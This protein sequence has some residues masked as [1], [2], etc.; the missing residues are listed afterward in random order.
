M[1][2]TDN[3]A[4]ITH[5]VVHIGV[6]GHPR[7]HA[8]PRR[9]LYSTQYNAAHGIISISLHGSH[10]I[11]DNAPRLL[12]AALYASCPGGGGGSDA[13]EPRDDCEPARLAFTEEMAA[14]AWLP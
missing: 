7:G 2:F 5:R 1:D 6:C 13:F 4:A 9:L 11:T 14:V 3:T 12:E 10:F 8:L